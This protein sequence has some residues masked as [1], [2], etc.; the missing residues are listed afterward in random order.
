MR[1][2][3]YAGAIGDALLDLTRPISLP[4]VRGSVTRRDHLPSRD[5]EGAKFH[6]RF[7]DN[8]KIS[9]LAR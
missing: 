1:K 5:R 3:Q 7:V 4:H 8:D 6:E 9:A 2:M